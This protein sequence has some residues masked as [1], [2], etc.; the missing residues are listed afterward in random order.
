[1]TRFLHNLVDNALTDLLFLNIGS[2]NFA[3][4]DIFE[5]VDAARLPV[6]LDER[7]SGGVFDLQHLARMPDAL[8]L[9]HGEAHEC[10]SRLGRNRI[11]DVTSPITVAFEISSLLFGGA[12]G[13]L[14]LGFLAGGLV[15]VKAAFFLRFVFGFSLVQIRRVD[16]S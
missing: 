1:M 11:V 12:R 9:L 7:F 15:P 2:V 3:L 4:G 10:P 5:P 13:R 6:K 16:F 14:G 8:A